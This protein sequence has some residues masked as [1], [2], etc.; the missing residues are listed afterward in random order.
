MLKKSVALS[1]TRHL[2]QAAISNIKS[3]SLLQVI[4]ASCFI[5]ICAQIK[6]PLYFTPVPFTIQGIGVML[7]GALLGSR[8]GALAVLGYLAQGSLGLP[9]WAGGGADGLAYLMGPTGGYL[10]AYVV[11]AFMIGFFVERLKNKNIFKLATI[12]LLSI[13]L[14]LSLGSLWLAQFVGLKSCFA[15]GCFPF[16][17]GDAA[18]ALMV[19]TALKIGRK[20]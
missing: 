6:I 9:V 10:M 19:A 1:S 8:K 17:L 5:A 16:I 3:S 11:Q 4:L 2:L 12:M 14:Q 18:K 20:K 15:L 13:S 7:V